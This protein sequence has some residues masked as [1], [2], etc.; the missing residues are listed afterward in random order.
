MPSQK[1]STERS[2]K[3]KSQP[4]AAV[5]HLSDKDL[6]KVAGGCIEIETIPLPEAKR[7]PKKKV[8]QPDPVD[9]FDDRGM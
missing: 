8:L 4:K 5:D 1:T 3:K 7:V 9:P 6:D 2:G